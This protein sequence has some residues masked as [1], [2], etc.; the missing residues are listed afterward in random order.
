MTFLQITWG[1]LKPQ[2]QERKVRLRGLKALIEGR[3]CRRAATLGVLALLAPFMSAN[4]RAQN[5][6]PDPDLQRQDVPHG[7]VTRFTLKGSKIY[8]GAEHQVTLYVP[9]QYDK[10]TPACVMI[11]QDGLGFNAPTVFDNLIAKKQMPVC[12]AIGVA[13]GVAPPGGPDPA[14]ALPRYNRSVEYDTPDDTYARFLLD[15]VLPEIGKTVNLSKSPDDRALC[16]GSSGGIAAFTAAWE[17]PDQFHRVYSVI[18]SF[19]DLAGGDTYPSKIRKS[20]P[21]PLRVF[22]QDNDRDQDIYSGSWPLANQEVAASL[23]YAGYDYQ[24][25]VGQGGHDGRPGSQIFPTVLR[26][27]WRDYPAP[28]KAN[29]TN[30]QP[31]TQ[32]LAPGEDWQQVKTSDF[33]LIL[34]A[35]ASGDVYVTNTAQTYLAH[36]ADA[37]VSVPAAWGSIVWAGMPDGRLLVHDYNKHSFAALSAAGAKTTLARIET[38]NAAVVSHQGTIYFLDAYGEVWM[39][40]RN[41]RKQPA[42]VALKE[43][44]E[45]KQGE[46]KAAKGSSRFG[47]EKF[48][49]VVEQALTLS[50]DQSLLI[51]TGGG[52]RKALMSWRVQ[53]D[54]TLT[55]GQP[56]FDLTTAYHQN[57]THVAA[58]VCDTQGWLY[59]ATPAGIQICDQAG[60]VNGILALP[61]PFSDTARI[62]WGGEPLVTGMAWG[63]PNHDTLYLACDGK[64]YRR[65]LRAKG[66]LP[67]DT[68]VKPPSVRL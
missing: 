55:D 53:A 40:G 37:S 7:V 30:G 67:F 26:W 3:W 2:Q 1:R 39:I 6:A 12:V 41:G 46:G 24:F 16:G 48:P 9:A 29:V 19:T 38:P 14:N 25:V 44:K 45:E 57:G 61:P 23:K 28:I 4:V 60:R 10:N 66:V 43:G 47:R 62:T 13:P 8:P 32:L 42:F 33:A 36:G 27:L 5:N 54:G 21:K 18:G 15:E 34:T 52:P 20:E 35:T 22:L 49:L 11:F 64:L 31:V 63:G 56:F 65:K 50:P 51:A 17:R 59:A 68:P 58:L